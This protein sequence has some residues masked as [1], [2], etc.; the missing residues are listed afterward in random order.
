[1]FVFFLVFFLLLYSMEW[2]I[3]KLEEWFFFFMLF[4]FEFFLCVD[5]LKVLKYE[6]VC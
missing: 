4:F 2:G 1:M 5:L 3:E 6:D